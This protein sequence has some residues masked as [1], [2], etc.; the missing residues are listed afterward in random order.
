M[1]FGH[2]EDI[3]GHTLHGLVRNQRPL[4]FPLDI[5]II[6]I[7]SMTDRT[8]LP[9]LLDG[10]VQ[11]DLIHLEPSLHVQG[12][13]LNPREKDVLDLCPRYFDEILQVLMLK[14][15]TKAANRARTRCG[16]NQ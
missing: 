15:Q 12:L 11:T 1:Y 14:T 8:T 16:S 6:R 7:A 4:G 10:M 13:L 3:H 9:D 2:G 5:P